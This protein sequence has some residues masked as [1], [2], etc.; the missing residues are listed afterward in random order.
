MGEHD[1]VLKEVLVVYR[2]RRVLEA[3]ST[4]ANYSRRVKKKEDTGSE[5]FLLQV[6]KPTIVKFK[7]LY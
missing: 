3:R 5:A 4:P 2:A 7:V 6:L 1:E